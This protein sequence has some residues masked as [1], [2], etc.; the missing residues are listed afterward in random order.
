MKP[1]GT[2]LIVIGGVGRWMN[3]LRSQL[4]IL[5][6]GPTNSNVLIGEWIHA[7]LHNA[8]SVLYSN[9]IGLL[10]FVIWWN[11]CHYFSHYFL[12]V[13]TLT[14]IAQIITLIYIPITKSL[15]WFSKAQKPI[16]YIF[17]PIIY[18]CLLSGPKH[19]WARP[20]EYFF[21]TIDHKKYLNKKIT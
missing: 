7:P 9:I 16:I 3:L 5:L 1:T 18:K 6:G 4:Q 14:L 11:S 15:E 8:V 19:H 13:F 12:T 21:I 20:C 2:L 17:D 10:N